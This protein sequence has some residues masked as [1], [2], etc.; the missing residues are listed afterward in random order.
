MGMAPE[1]L[2]EFLMRGAVLCVQLTPFTK[3]D[4][5]DI[6]GLRENTRFLIERSK[7]KPLV[8]IPTG[9]TG[10]HYALTEE[11]RKKVIKTVIDEANGKVPIIAG[12]GHSGTKV[13]VELSKYAED[14]GADG[15]MIVLPYY[16]VPEEEG[17]YRHFKA[18]ADAVDIGLLIY[19]NPDVSKVY[20][21]PELMKRIVELPN[22]VGIKENTPY[23]PML[24]KQIKA[25]GDKVPILQGRGEWWFAAT[26]ILGVRGYISGYVQFMPEFSFE[27]LEAGLK[28][29]WNKV[30][31]LMEKIRPYEEFI[32]KMSRKHGPSTTILPHPYVSSYMIYSV[33]KKTMDMLGLHGGHMRLPLIDIDEKDEEELRKIVFEEL[34]LRPIK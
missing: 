16:H 11:E 22:V 13:A 14:V 12:T 7:G 23:I 17:M 29:D 8:L 26:A 25:V 27:L 3:D 32:D 9:S 4:E 19:N 18:I 1:K 28:G 30:K 6:E 33:M 20:I 24:Y 2:R 31:E 34:G 10:E 21:F 5:V 15:V